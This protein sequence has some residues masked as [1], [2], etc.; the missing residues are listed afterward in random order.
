[1]INGPQEFSI[2]GSNNTP[3]KRILKSSNIIHGSFL[4][5]FINSHVDG[6]LNDSNKSVDEESKTPSVIIPRT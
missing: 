6:E 2:N 4:T 3:W 1:L 5:S